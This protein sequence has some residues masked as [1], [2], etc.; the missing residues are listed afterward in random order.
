MCIRACGF[1]VPVSLL[2]SQS[3][4]ASAPPQG[5]KL[6]KSCNL[7]A[8]KERPPVWPEVELTSVPPIGMG[9]ALAR[10]LRAT[11]RPDAGRISMREC[12]LA[13]GIEF[14]QASLRPD[15]GGCEAL[16]VPLRSGQFRIVVDATPRNGWDE[17]P[18]AVRTTVARH[19][20][21]FRLAHELAHT[22]FYRK[23]EGPPARL[24]SSGSAAEEL[25]ADEF[26]RA[27]L[28]P[29]PQRPVSAREIVEFQNRWDVSLEVAVRAC[30]EASNSRCVVLWRW[31]PSTS[32][33]TPT[34]IQWSTGL[35][36]ASDLGL[37]RASSTLDRL[38]AAVK[39]AAR[40]RSRSVLRAFHNKVR[41]GGRR[42]LVAW[43]GQRLRRSMTRGARR[44]SSS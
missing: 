28:A 3:Y 2:H 42:T 32:S 26:A 10:E 34:A 14:R 31:A 36:F 13:A 21:R 29:A 33:V 39:R 22:L 19:R 17:T 12:C 7:R 16:L 41:V 23:G 8:L 38:L 4:A 20:T 6:L 11:M 44:V 43:S 18:T 35:P 1:I 15:Q 9:A 30:A 27:L 25:F 5:A 24:L 37:P 40:H